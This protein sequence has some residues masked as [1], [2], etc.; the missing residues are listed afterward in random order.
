L[1]E[2]FST[3]YWRLVYTFSDKTETHT[4]DGISVDFRTDFYGEFQRFRD[5]V[6]ERDV[7]REILRCLEPTDVFYDVGANVGMYT[8]FVASELGAE[9]TVAFEPYKENADRLLENLR[10]NGL[11]ARVVR[12]A[13]SNAEG[14]VDLMIASEQIG[15]GEHAIATSDAAQ[16]IEIDTN[17]GDTLIEDRDLPK[18][19]VVKIDVE[20]AE[21]AVLEGLRSALQDSCRLVFCE[22][23]PQKLRNLGSDE[24]D[25]HQL[26]QSN[27]F[28]TEVIHRRGEEYFVKAERTDDTTT[29]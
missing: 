10:Y 3:P 20:G 19:T 15:E 2:L 9:R 5:L 1:N 28:E 13:L 23:H 12:T 27:G 25:I 21:F 18:P 26:L 17:R 7:I 16:T 24:E 4:I 29:V 14:T 6:G 8:C 22:I 11:N